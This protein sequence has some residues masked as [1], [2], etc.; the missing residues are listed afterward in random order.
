MK[1]GKRFA[2]A[3]LLLSFFI[4][5]NIAAAKYSGGSGTG[6]DPYQISNATDLLTLG[7]DS[8]D[9][10][11]HF[12]L[13]ADIDLDPNLPGNHIFTSAVIAPDINNSNEYYDGRYFTGVFNGN[14]HTI[15]NLTIHSDGAYLGLFGY[16]GACVDYIDLGT[17]M[18][19]IRLQN[20][21]ISGAHFVGALAGQSGSTIS[22]CSSTG[23][24]NG[25]I[26]AG[27]LIGYNIGGEVSN[28][29]STAAVT[30]EYYMGGLVGYFYDGYMNLCYFTGSA[31]G[32]GYI[33]GLTGYNYYG[34]ISKCYSTGDISSGNTLG[35]LV[36]M[37]Y[38]GTISDCYSTG[39]VSGTGGIGGLVGGNAY[40][41]RIFNCYSRGTVT[42]DSNAV[43]LGGLLGWRWGNDT[44]ITNDYFLVTSGP[45]NGHGQPLTD[46][47]MKQK[48]NFVKWNFN[49]TWWITEGVSYPVLV[50]LPTLIQVTQCSITAGNKT[51]SDAISI[52]GKINATADDFSS[53]SVIE[54]TVDSNDIVNPCVLTFPI[55]DTTFKIKNGTYSYS[56]TENKLRKSFT[57]NVKTHKFAFSASTVDLSGLGCPVTAKIDIN[58]FNATADLYEPIV[59]G[60]RMPIPMLLMMGVKD[61]LKVDK[62]TVKQNAK[63]NKDQL[64]VSG[65]F[66]VKDTD[67]NM[68]VRTSEGLTIT[69]DSQQVDIPANKL[70]A[71][72]GTFTCSNA[73]IAGGNG[74]AA[75]TFNFN[76]CSFTLTIKDANIPPISSAV[77]FGVKFADFNEVQQVTLP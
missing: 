67:A 39:N 17:Q 32:A 63:P 20:V 57:Y 19:N 1:A 6:G 77:D 18:K 53:A 42:G 62:C 59:N 2:I 72:R 73:K 46:S 56:G 76:L 10:N 29:H 24:V 23:I 43:D 15:S 25:G 31:A 11:K 45:D 21:N 16:A 37:N 71:G 51:N 49:S 69:L 48:K 40:G 70:K 35:G 33:G 5:P 28:C 30:G 54:V 26:W 74:T 22:N 50:W 65:A 75:A 8:N 58:D 4:Q 14:G 34:T 12:V 36:G 13:T 44:Y 7:A 52:S 64:T 38:Y 68:A 66:A 60:P 27:G 9:Y 3:V 41:G 61:V 55:N 47:Q